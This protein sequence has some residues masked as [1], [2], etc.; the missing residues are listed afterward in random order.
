MVFCEWAVSWILL[1]IWKELNLRHLEQF[2]QEECAKLP[3][4]RWIILTKRN[5]LFAVI[6]SK[7][8]VTKYWVKGTMV[9]VQAKVWFLF[10]WFL[11]F[12]VF[13]FFV[14]FIF[15]F[16]RKLFFFRGREVE[17]VQISYV[18][19]V[20][21][22]FCAPCADEHSRKLLSGSFKVTS[23]YYKVIKSYF[24]VQKS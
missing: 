15:S 23:D 22:A 24:P 5:H 9:F 12:F 3:V 20:S 16:Y 11:E 21:M 18:V 7:G 4:G 17:L 6:L 10:L 8:C 19:S 1:N 13:S 14:I 2:A